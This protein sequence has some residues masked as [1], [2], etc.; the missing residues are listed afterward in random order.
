MRAV[1][2][3]VR[4]RSRNLGR[5]SPVSRAR[6]A[7]AA[8]GAGAAPPLAAR[9]LPPPC[10][11]LA[12]CGAFGCFSAL[13][14]SAMDYALSMISPDRRATRAFLPSASSRTPTRVGLS[15]CGSTSITLD[16]WI[17]PSRSMMPPWRSFCVG[18]WCFLIML[19]RSTMTRPFSGTTRSTLPRLPR[20]FPATTIT[21]SPFRT[22][23]IAMGLSSNPLPCPASDDFRGQRNDLRELPVAKLPSD[24]PEDAR[25][26]GV[27]VGLEQDDGVAIEADVG[28][29]LAADLLHRPDHHRAGDLALLDGPVRDR[30]L[31]GDDD[32]VAER[33]VALV[34]AAHDADALGL[35]GARVVRDVDHAAGL[36]HGWVSGLLTMPGPG[37][38]E[39]A[40]A[41]PSTADA[42]PRS[43]PC[44][45]PSSRSSRRGP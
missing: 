30:L 31:H 17:A 33:G 34:G 21:V 38:G 26:H 5:T 23:L 16:R 7:G 11:V 28:A 12:P 24:R 9:C 1:M 13:P 14:A 42:S 29:V 35:L 10:W 19:T 25:P 6:Q 4:T 20:S 27:V 18:R 2:T 41:C 8:A 15:D 22:C 40:T 37:P 32:D 43:G 45:R 39:C 3:A 36:D 44:R